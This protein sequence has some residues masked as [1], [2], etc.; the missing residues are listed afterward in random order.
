MSD[1]IKE[2]EYGAEPSDSA[3]A[4]SLLEAHQHD[5]V[6]TE[7]TEADFLYPYYSFSKMNTWKYFFFFFKYDC[8]ISDNRTYSVII[9][10][11]HLKTILS[12]NINMISYYRFQD[13]LFTK[14]TCSINIIRENHSKNLK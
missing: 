13:K 12:I 11:M 3:D 6:R 10:Y 4:T 2:M 9:N 8:I 14:G 7:S 5:Q 1:I